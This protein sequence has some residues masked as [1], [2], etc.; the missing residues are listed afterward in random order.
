MPP[1]HGKSELIS[2][3]FPFW[4]LGNFPDHRVLLTSY[5][6]TFAASWG[7][8]VRDLMAERGS[9]LFGIK[10]DP[11][12]K[13]ASDFNIFMRDGG[14]SC[15][16][17]GGAITGKGADLLI[18]D[19]PVKNDTEAMSIT[20]RESVWDWFASVAYTRLAPGGIIVVVMTRWHED[21]LCGRLM[22]S[23]IK[24]KGTWP[25]TWLRLPV[26]ANSDDVLGR[27]KGE[28]LWPERF[29]SRRIED[30]RKTI[31]EFWF[32][33]LY[34]QQPSPAT[35]GIFKRK[36]FRYYEGAQDYY[37]LK[38]DGGEDE[39]IPQDRIKI[40]AVADL[41]ATLSQTSDYT[42]VL[43]FGLTEKRDTL[44]LD[45]IRERFEGADHLNMIKNV[46]RRWRPVLI[47]VESSQYQISLVQSAMREGLPV[48]ELKPDS[49]KLSRALPMA[50]RM[51]SGTVYFPADSPWLDDFEKE[52]LSFP[53]GKHDDQVDALAYIVEIVRPVSGALPAGVS[54]RDIPGRERLRIGSFK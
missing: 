26:Y 44:V 24:N 8:K 42:V 27:P 22:K 2:K 34:Q 39:K 4:Y 43:I 49:D 40:Y 11:S 54:F 50:A 5:E 13:S 10:L 9:D 29:P 46:N 35:G 1:R 12:S 18:I 48:R 19:D 16:G 37:I 31:G 17:S 45:I 30:I 32:S 25:W 51:E 14:M 38:R 20:Y 53:K 23:D 3:F 15:A 33:A 41:A 36:Y 28:I 52:L 47:G 21:D 7:R 6:A